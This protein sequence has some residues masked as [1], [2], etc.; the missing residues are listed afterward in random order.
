MSDRL[1]FTQ[2]RAQFRRGREKRPG[3]HL[4]DPQ[5]ILDPEMEIKLPLCLNDFAGANFARRARNCATDFHV[6]ES[7][8][9]TKRMR[10][11]PIAQQDA[12][13]ISPARVQRRLG[14][15]PLRFI[16]DVVVDERRDVDQL[17]NYRKIDMFRC[18]LADHTA[19]QQRD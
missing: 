11:K 2:H 16:H 18:D 4:N 7:G 9:Q 14:A 8:R 3:F 15:T 17:H 1:R 13:R 19:A 5:V 12:E 10:K 6:I